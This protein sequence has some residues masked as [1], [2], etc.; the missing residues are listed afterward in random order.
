MNFLLVLYSLTLTVAFVQ[1]RQEKEALL[2]HRGELEQ[3]VQEL[4]ST[5]D[6]QR[7]VLSANDAAMREA[8]ARI[9]A[10][11]Q[12]RD[13]LLANLAAA[14]DKLQRADPDAAG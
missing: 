12:E 2:Y 3:R 4:K 10:M 14:E 1:L 9:I 5:A 6:K 11:T 8:K 13:T 7:T